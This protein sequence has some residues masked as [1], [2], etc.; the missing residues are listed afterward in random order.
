MREQHLVYQ[1]A[2][3][4][5]VTRGLIDGFEGIAGIRERDAGAATAEVHESQHALRGQAGLVL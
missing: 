4:L 2:G 1:S 5:R 3:E